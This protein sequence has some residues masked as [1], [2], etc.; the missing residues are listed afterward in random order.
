MILRNLKTDLW[1]I[2]SGYGFYL[3]IIF[4]CLLCFASYIYE[5]GVTGNKYSVLRALWTF[6]RKFMLEDLRFC[7][8]EVVRSS[9][10]NW[11]F[12]FIPIIASFA[13]VPLGCDE[14]EAKSVRFQVF[15]TNRFCYNSSRFI[16]G[17]LCGGL[18]VMMGF[19]IF[20]LA[21]HMLFPAVS[22]YS[23]ELQ[24]QYKEMMDSIH[25]RISGIYYIQAVMFKISGM[26]LYG[27][28][29]AAPIMMMT[30]FI[31]NKYLVMCIPFFVKY[32]INQTCEKTRWHMLENPESV[33][34]WL[35]RIAAFSDPDQLADL[36]DC[37][38]STGE[39]LL[40]HGLLVVLFYV[41][42]L[43]VQSRRGDCGE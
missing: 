16:T 8:F 36:A 14:Y 12:L 7:S 32:G 11:L 9:A 28:F 22:T 13:F 34:T 27:V 2:L 38:N 37:G 18:A 17:C 31:R 41:V 25:I 5:D 43:V 40:Y 26:F 24:G 6:D 30:A 4:T 29:W 15:R 1:K 20:T 42:Y 10:G 3:C 35:R 39:V 33:S 23:P 21:V 19:V